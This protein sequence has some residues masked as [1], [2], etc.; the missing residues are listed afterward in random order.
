MSSIVRKSPVP[1]DIEIAQAATMQPIQA[2]AEKAGILE[3]ELE[4]Y[5]R[6][7]AKIDYMALLDRLKQAATNASQILREGGTGIAEL[8]M[9]AEQKEQVA[10]ITAVVGS[11]WCTIM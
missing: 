4:L 3:D 9:T 10:Q 11:A 2:I 7:K 5:G 6:F 1:S 8:F